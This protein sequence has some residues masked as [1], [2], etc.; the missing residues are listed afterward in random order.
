MSTYEMFWDCASCGTQKLLGKTHRRCPECGAPQDASRRYFPEEHEKIAVH[1]HV[2]V[3]RDY[4]C[5]HC[6][7]PNSRAAKHCVQ[8]GAPIGDD[9]ADVA[10]VE[11]KPEPEAPASSGGFFG[12]L[13]SRFSTHRKALVSALV[14]LLGL[15]LLCAA[16]GAV[17]MFWTREALVEAKGHRWSRTISIERFSAVSEGEWCDR[18]PSDA[19][20]VSRSTRQRDTKRIPDGEDCTT[21]NVDNGDGTFRQEQKCTTRYREEP[22]YGDWCDY[23]VNR[24]VHAHDET[25]RGTGRSPA[26]HWPSVSVSNCSSLGCTRMGRRRAKYVVTYREAGRDEELE[27][28]FPEEKWASIEPGSRWSAEVRVATG[29][30]VCDSL[31]ESR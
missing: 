28:D 23:T 24:W 9:D 4:E 3:G 15:T 27:C 5:A 14:L 10:L 29:G 6:Q 26:P 30:L 31:R 19:Y 22:I 7:A 25:A 8:C 11:E 21:V 17:T 18:M 20:G 2:Y 12:F 1:D 16:M 13:K